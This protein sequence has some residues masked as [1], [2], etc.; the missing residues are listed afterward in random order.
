[1]LKI[2]NTILAQF[3]TARDE[4]NSQIPK[5]K[6]KKKEFVSVRKYFGDAGREVFIMDAKGS[7]NIGRYLNVSIS[8]AVLILKFSKRLQWRPI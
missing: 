8:F 1:M 5:K 3:V 4:V 6:E 2:G 7:G